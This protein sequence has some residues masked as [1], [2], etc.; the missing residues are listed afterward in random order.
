[1]ICNLKKLIKYII[2]LALF[3]WFYKYYIFFY[4]IIFKDNYLIRYNWKGF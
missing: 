1:M 4:N 2:N 3:I